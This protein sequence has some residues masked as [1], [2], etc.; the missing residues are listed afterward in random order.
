MMRTPLIAAVMLVVAFGTAA[1]NP[2]GTN[3]VINEIYA[4]PPGTY[5][6]AEFIELYNPTASPIDISG[7]VLTGTEYDGL[8]GGEDVWYFPPATTIAAGGYV[9]VAKDAHD[10]EDGFYENFGFD[11]DFELFDPTFAYDND[12]AGTPDMLIANDDPATNYSDEIGLV[13]GSGYGRSCSGSYNQSEVLYL[14]TSATFITLVDLFE[15]INP[16]LCS[17]DPCVGDDGA[18]DNAFPEIPYLGNTLGRSPTSVDTD[19]SDVDLAM[20]VP[21]PGAVNTANTPPW[22]RDVLYAPIP[23]VETADVAVSAVVTDDSGIDSVMVYYNVDAAGWQ[24]VMASTSDSLYTG[25]IPKTDFY[26][27]A[28]VEYYVR[29]VDNQA[30][31]LNYPAEG[32]AGPYAFSV[33]YTAIADVQSAPDISPLV[34]QSVN[35][36]GIVTAAKGEFS[37]SSFWMHE[38]NGPYQGIQCYVPGYEGVINEGDDVTVCG[39]VSEYYNMTELIQHFAGALVVHSTGNPNYG[40]ASVTTAQLAPAGTLGELWE[41]QLV[42]ITD[43]TVTLIPDNY[44]QWHIQDA[45]AVDCDVDDYAYY[46]YVPEVLDKLS[47]IRGIVMYSY[48]E[49]KLEPRYD[50][51]IIGPPRVGD[52]RYSPIP[53]TAAG[54]V[55]VSA[56][57]EDNSDI[58]SATLSWSLSPTGPFTNVAMTQTAKAVA[59]TWAA[60]VGP[61]ANNARVYYYVTGVDDAVP[62]MD[63]RRP[64]AGSYSF[65]VGTTAISNVQAVGPDLDTSVMD[66]LAVNVEGYVTAEPGIFGD[67]QFYIADAAGAWNGILVYDRSGSLSFDRGDYIVACGE[68]QEYYGHTQLALHFS[69]CAQL[70]TP[71]TREAIAPVSIA[72]A[73][74]QN[75]ITG[76]KYESVYVHAEDCTVEDADLGYGEWM[77]TNGGSTD[78]CRV[79]DYAAYDYVPVYGDNVYVKGLVAYAY[80]SYRI[81]PRGNEDIAVN[82]V[83]I[84][85][86]A[87]SKFGLAQNSP[88]PFNPKTSIAFSLPESADVAL[89]IYDVAGRKVAT[90][91]EGNLPAGPYSVEWNG[92][93]DGGEKVASGVYFYRLSAGEKETSK[94]MV[95][96]K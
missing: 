16:D 78:T 75:V 79:A 8:C 63:A 61:F 87:A 51:D 12:H 24:R 42:S 80:G 20:Q 90:L 53:P 67:Y 33:G 70:A 68:V 65:Y 9:I 52:V 43:A 10:G 74:L 94:K 41:S 95:L 30:A 1:A 26:D 39:T 18:D 37:N 17:A 59:E 15:Y 62:A 21:T 76:E 5:D 82:P 46:T 34:G 81:E 11:P 40:Y 25:T 7:W 4:N 54:Q 77:I 32:P 56:V 73:E 48:S 23:P 36:R 84:P 47:E 3:V 64:S 22:L 6:G 91:V 72:T 88:N 49:Y 45:S 69:E 57:F 19:N 14:Y 27:G 96:L 71:P 89:S 35:L 60:S 38:G 86:G 66:T 44:G 29:G 28:Q 93:T 92:R 83:G 85:D 55:T 2:S 13:G 31:G 50:E 58:A